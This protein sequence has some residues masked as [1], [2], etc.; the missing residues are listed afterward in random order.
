MKIIF[1][2]FKVSVAEDCP[3]SMMR[4]NFFTDYTVLKR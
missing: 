1:Q 4:D 2:A 3:L